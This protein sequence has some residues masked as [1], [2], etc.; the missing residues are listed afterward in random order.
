LNFFVNYGRLKN[1]PRTGWLNKGVSRT[2]VESVADHTCRVAMI[3]I[4]ISK[5]F[6]ESVDE[7]KI[8]KISLLHDISES[9]LLDIDKQATKLIGS[10]FKNRAE[11]KVEQFVL[12]DL[13][14]QIRIEFD[15]LLNEYH[16]CNSLEAR[17]V[18]FCDKLE[19]ILQAISYE[20]RGFNSRN[21]QEF[22]EEVKNLNFRNK[23]PIRNILKD[24]ENMIKEARA[25]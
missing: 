13:P 22:Y 24:L 5:L 4:I 3:A 23:K 18:K 2:E 11:K 19:M 10:T 12:K 21:L 25:R 20:D 17:I 8:V 16:A 7:S 9:H 14:Q 15:S 1:I 6:N